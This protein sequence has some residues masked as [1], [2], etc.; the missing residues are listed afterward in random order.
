[1]LLPGLID[2]LAPL[3]RG[4][5]RRLRRL[6]HREPPLR[7]RHQPGGEV[8]QRPVR[9]AR[10]RDDRFEPLPD[11]LRASRQVDEPIGPVLDRDLVP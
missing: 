2:R 6:Q 8:D 5:L 1:M 3:Q 9:R 11:L 4:Q 7:L 10:E